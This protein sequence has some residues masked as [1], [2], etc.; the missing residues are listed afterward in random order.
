M[1]GIKPR[2]LARQE[3]VHSNVHSSET[4]LEEKQLQWNRLRE[5]LE[6]A[7]VKMK[8]Y[9]DAKRTE[10]VFQKGNWAYLKF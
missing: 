5:L 3:R 9:A 1:Y 6:S 10:K 7:Q 4:M 2:H 8:T